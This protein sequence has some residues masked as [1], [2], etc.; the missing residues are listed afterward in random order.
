MRGAPPAT[1]AL[2]PKEVAALIVWIV[3]APPELVLKE[4]VVSP[5]LETGWP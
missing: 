1:E 3:A 4:A 5:L 2:P